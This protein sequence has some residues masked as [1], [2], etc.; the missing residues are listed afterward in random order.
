MIFYLYAPKHKKSKFM[1]SNYSGSNPGL[2]YRTEK[3][4]KENEYITKNKVEN[5][6]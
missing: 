3:N 6:L 1:S 2:K 4:R 5:K